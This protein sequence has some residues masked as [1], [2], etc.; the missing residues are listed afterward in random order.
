MMTALVENKRGEVFVDS[1]LIPRKFGMKHNKLISVVESVF[2][3]YKH[4]N[5][6]NTLNALQLS[7]LVTLESLVQ[8]SLRKYMSLDIH[9]KEIYKLVAN[10]ITQYASPLSLLEVH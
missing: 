1:A 4:T 3:D 8:A 6:R 7:W 10:D 5:L 9:Y 2:I